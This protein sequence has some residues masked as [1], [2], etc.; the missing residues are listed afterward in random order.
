MVDDDAGVVDDHDI[1]QRAGLGLDDLRFRC[2]ELPREL[3][4]WS[5]RSIRLM[6][7]APVAPHRSGA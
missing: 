4:M 5:T 3:P 1:E 2:V 7:G 6:R